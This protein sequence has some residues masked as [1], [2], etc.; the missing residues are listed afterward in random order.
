MRK[1]CICIVIQLIAIVNIQAQSGNIDPNFGNPVMSIGDSSRFN[2]GVNKIIIQPDGNL[3]AAGDFTTYNNTTHQYIVRLLQDDLPDTSFH[4]GTFDGYLNNMVLQQDNKIVV[5]GNFDFH[6][7]DTS[8]GILRLNPDGSVD[9]GFAFNFSLNVT[10]VALA[11]QQDGKIILGGNFFIYRGDSAKYLVRLNSDGTVDTSFMNNCGS[12]FDSWVQSL[13]IQTDGKIIAGGRF[14]EFN[15]TPCDHI[16]RLN[17]DGTMDMTFLTQPAFD[18]NVFSLCIQPDGKILAGGAFQNFDTTIQ[19]NIT[20][21]NTDGTRDTTFHSGKGFNDLVFEIYVQPNGK[22]LVGGRFA[23]Y[24]STYRRDCIIRLNIDGS[25]DLSFYSGAECSNTVST[26]AVE[27][28]GNILL[29]GDFISVNN[30]KRRYIARMNP[31]G[32]L[33]GTFSC[34]YGFE[35][36]VTKTFIQPDGK[37]MV[38]GAF[39]RYNGYIV[40]NF[41]RLFPDGSIDTTCH[42]RLNYLATEMALDISGNKIYIGGNFTS[43]NLMSRKSL[44]RVDMNGDVDPSFQV[45]VGFNAGVKAI[46]VQPDGKIIVGGAFTSYDSTLAGGII[47][48]NIDG[49]IDTTFDYGTGFNNE[50]KDIIIQP[51]GKVL[52]CG[53]FTNYNGI[54]ENRIVRLN[55]NGVFDLTFIPTSGFNDYAVSMA[56][57]HDGKIIA[58]G[59]FTQYNGIPSGRLVRINSD[60]SYDNSFNSV[61]GFSNGT[62]NEII[63][64][65]DGKILAAG[66]FNKYNNEISKSVVRINPDGNFDNTFVAGMGFNGKLRSISLQTDGKLICGGEYTTYQQY[67]I[68]YL[69]RLE[70]F[71]PVSINEVAETGRVSIFPNPSLGIMNINLD[72]N[73]T[74]PADMKLTTLMGQ[75]IQNIKLLSRNTILNVDHAKGIYLMKIS[76]GKDAINKKIIVE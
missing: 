50:V 53:V 20:R 72:D 8:S 56:L 60:G 68:N 62:V 66:E 10:G 64:Q 12:G 3:L 70:S 48:L 55:P 26:F 17:S 25:K 52:V 49:T 38:S 65:Q 29:G 58:G 24:D 47:R 76:N 59:L 4:S 5:C 7:N 67:Y 28:N 39:G 57:Q 73:F 37:I 40:S 22:I 33:D 45:G 61:T 41:I 42:T 35:S 31:D 75:E 19:R 21:L 34:E 18:A 6:D 44:V 51:D 71:I 11:L 46:A 63:L 32:V 2:G 27:T 16:V 54:T 23:L 14:T 43:C 9:T 13:V 15:G 69:S 74:L 1:I 36:I 30:T